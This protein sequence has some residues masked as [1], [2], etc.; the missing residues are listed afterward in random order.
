MRVLEE[1]DLRIE[2]PDD[3][4]S[5]EKF[6][7]HGSHG[8]SHCMKAVD[9]IIETDSHIWFIEIKDPDHPQAREK[10]RQRFLR[11]LQSSELDRD[12]VQKFRDS[13]L[14]R[15]AEDRI[16]KPIR[17]YIIIASNQLDEALLLSRIDALKQKLPLTGPRSG[18]WKR[19]LVEGCGI[20]NLRTWKGAFPEFPLSRIS[21]RIS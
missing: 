11:D 16:T 17:Y 18:R 7:D 6:D 21:G 15:W 5:V 14:Y 13:F 3:V 2:I 8:L 20:Y 9:F 10:D 12:L 19:R 1:G 4:Q